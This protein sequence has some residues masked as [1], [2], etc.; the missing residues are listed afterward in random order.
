VSGGIGRYLKNTNRSTIAVFGGFAYQTTQYTQDIETQP[1]QNVA[2]AMVGANVVL[3]KFNKTNLTFT[4]KAFPA[5]S[6]PG[7]LYVLSDASYFWKLG[8][9]IT[10]NVSFYGNWD[11]QPPAHFSGSDYGTSSGI[12]WTFGNR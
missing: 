8:H 12:G 2:A 10:W 3:F 9:N 7:R 6:D 11:T 1:T 4:T 5:I